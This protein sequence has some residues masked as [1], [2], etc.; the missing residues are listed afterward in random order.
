MLNGYGAQLHFV[1]TR[2]SQPCRWGECDQFSIPIPFTPSPAP[3]QE[4]SKP[5]L[6]ISAFPLHL[7][8]EYV[9]DGLCLISCLTQSKEYSPTIELPHTQPPATGSGTVTSGT[10]AP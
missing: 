8:G 10:T 3:C 1:D 2:L 7:W 9:V 4:S 5:F 6:F